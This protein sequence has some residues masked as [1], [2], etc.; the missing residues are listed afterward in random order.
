[1]T[2]IIQGFETKAFLVLAEI[3]QELP[4]SLILFLFYNSELLD[5]CQRSKEGLSIIDFTNDVN[6]L[7]YSRSIESNC[8]ILEVSY[9]RYLVQA[10][11]YEIKFVSSKYELIYFTRNHYQFNLQASIQLSS[12]EKQPSPNIK[13][14][15]V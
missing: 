4:F 12:I 15:K 11:R 6:I 9:I 5:L 13:V 10:R 8:R 2:L 14:L 3:P 7:V 1:M